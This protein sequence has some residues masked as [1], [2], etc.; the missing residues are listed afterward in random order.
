MVFWIWHTPCRNAYAYS[1][2]Y[3][4]KVVGPTMCK[5]KTNEG[6]IDWHKLEKSQF[7]Q[8]TRFKLWKY[9]FYLNLKVY[10]TLNLGAQT[11]LV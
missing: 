6:K 1:A 2:S 8:Y 11:P 3:I 4:F 10:K 9:D 5:V 7:L